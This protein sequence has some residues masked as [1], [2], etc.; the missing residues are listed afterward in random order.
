[1]PLS[2]MAKEEEKKKKMKNPLENRLRDH[3]APKFQP[4]SRIKF[5]QGLMKDLRNFTMSG[6]RIPTLLCTS[7]CC[8]FHSSLF[9][10]RLCIVSIL[11][12]LRHC[13]VSL[14]QK[15]PYHEVPH[16]DR[17][18]SLRSQTLSGCISWMGLQI[19]KLGKGISV[20]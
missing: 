8:V 5:N 18:N 7:D 1:M 3:G 20:F 9:R 19:A 16:S 11:P 13:M 12:L 17:H 4:E 15:S 2:A 10:M 6:H 14:S